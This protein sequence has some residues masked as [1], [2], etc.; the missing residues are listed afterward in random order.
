MRKRIAMMLLVIG[1]L[2]MIGQGGA[3]LSKNLKIVKVPDRKAGDKPATET[4]VD[5]AGNP[6]VA[7]DKGYA[8]IRY[9]YYPGT[10]WIKSMELLDADGNPVNGKDGYA[11]ME[12]GAD[13]RIRLKS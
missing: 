4:Y 6:V 9:T 2:L 13:M 11:R 1:A 5:E 10:N 7:S 12:R 8:T 3:E